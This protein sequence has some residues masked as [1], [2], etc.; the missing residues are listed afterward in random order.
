M[1]LLDDVWYHIDEVGLN[2]Y[3]E[4]DD[5]VEQSTWGLLK[6]FFKKLLD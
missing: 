5:P 1:V 2:I 3:V 4:E 6:S